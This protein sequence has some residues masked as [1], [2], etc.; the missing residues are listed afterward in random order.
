MQ[1]YGET[2]PLSESILSSSDTD[3]IPKFED[4][5]LQQQLKLSDVEMGFY[6]SIGNSGHNSFNENFGSSHMNT[7]FHMRSPLGSVHSNHSGSSSANIMLMQKI[8][9][10]QNQVYVINETQKR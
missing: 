5:A 8:E 3:Y 9:S 10:L 2:F 1:Q 4:L 7:G 6:N